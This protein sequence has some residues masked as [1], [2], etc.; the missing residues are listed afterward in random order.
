MQEQINT[1]VE[2][3]E[4]KENLDK[5]ESVGPDRVITVFID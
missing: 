5:Y 1:D 2:V 4:E 3:F